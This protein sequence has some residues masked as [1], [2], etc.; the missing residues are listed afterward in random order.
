M[1]RTRIVKGNI[2]KIIGGNYKRYS[3]DDIVNI[4]SKVIQVGKEG[5]VTYGEPE[6]VPKLDVSYIDNSFIPIVI[7]DSTE[8]SDYIVH[9]DEN[10][11]WNLS[12]HIESSLRN[13]KVKSIEFLNE[14]KIVNVK[15]KILKGNKKAN[16]KDGGN[17]TAKFFDS[18]KK[19]I[20]KERYE[21]LA[22]KKTLKLDWDKSLN[23]EQVEFYADDNDWFF[24]GGISNIFCG[25]IKIYKKKCIYCDNWENVPR[26]MP[27]ASFVG[28]GYNGVRKNCFDY[29]WKQIKDAGYDLK[30]TSWGNSKKM[31]DNIYQIYLSEDVADMKKGVQKD[32]FKKGIEYLKESIKKRIPVMVGVDDAPGS[33]NTDKVTDHFVVIVGMGSDD[34]GNYFLFDDNATSSIDVGTSDLNKIYCICDEYKLE[35]K[36]DPKNAYFTNSDYK[37]YIITQIRETK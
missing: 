12:Y 4:G 36:A 28:W 35:G 18:D 19:L 34:N 17:I 23:I 24:D 16:D 6:E 7:V 25:A 10:L 14:N 13:P 11:I 9:T 8:N 30:S 2:T 1:S 26:I 20:K 32:Q 3:K 37:K 31:N 15:F 22:Y 5:G 21:D 33:P 27:K 29:A